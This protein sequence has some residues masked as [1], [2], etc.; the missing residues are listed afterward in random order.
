MTRYLKKKVRTV[1][2]RVARGK[3]G[4][5]DVGDGLAFSEAPWHTDDL[6]FRAPTAP[7][8][9]NVQLPS[10]IRSTHSPKPWCCF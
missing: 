9:R 8:L 3:G 1:H 6:A 2:W 5:G 4:G 10:F 7:P